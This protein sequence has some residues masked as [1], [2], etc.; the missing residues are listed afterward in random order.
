MRYRIEQELG[1]KIKQITPHIDQ[2]IPEVYCEAFHVVTLS[3]EG[4]V[5]A[6]GDSMTFLNSLPRNSFLFMFVNFMYTVVVCIE[7]TWLI[8]FEFC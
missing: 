4:L 3:E 8:W 2:I 7:I 1:T 6:W 5:Q